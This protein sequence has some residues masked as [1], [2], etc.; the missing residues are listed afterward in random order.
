MTQHMKFGKNSFMINMRET[1]TIKNELTKDVDIQDL[2]DGSYKLYV[3]EDA[4]NF[5]NKKFSKNF[6]L[7]NGI[8]DNTNQFKLFI[9]TKMEKGIET[10][11]TVINLNCSLLE[12]CVRKN[13]P[14][15]YFHF[16]KTLCKYHLRY[17]RSLSEIDNN[18]TN[19]ANT[20]ANIIKGNSK[21]IT[22]KVVEPVD[23]A[24]DKEIPDY[25]SITVKL[26]KYQKCSIA[27]MI[28]KERSQKIIDYNLNDEIIM[29]NVYFDSYN[30]TINLLEK[31]KQI[32]FIGGALIDEVGLGKTL[33]M[34]V[35]SMKK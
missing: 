20:D 31:R 6:S 17:T 24:F 35:L 11:Y 15:P 10:M 28:K 4:L 30:Q 1:I 23:F 25:K 29:G 22:E 34:T 16:V 7:P 19:V 12:K 8:S 3:G 2:D 18:Y 33:Q 21:Y 26:K 5:Y 27:W 32:K 13:V 14:I 9:Y